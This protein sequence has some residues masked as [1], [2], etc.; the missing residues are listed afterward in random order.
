M[1][2]E[3]GNQTG[4]ALFFYGFCQMSKRGWELKKKSKAVKE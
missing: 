1:V 3:G 4:E 2:D